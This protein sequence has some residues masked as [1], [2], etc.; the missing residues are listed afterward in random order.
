MGG[1]SSELEKSVN[2][3]QTEL[4][5][6][7]MV[8]DVTVPPAFVT[9]DHFIANWFLWKDKFLAYLKKIDKAEDKKQLW[10]IMLLNRMGPVGQEI[11]RTFPFYN[12]NAQE[13]INVLI[14]KFDIYCMYRNEK[15][16]CKDINRYTSDLIF[17]AVTWNHVDPTGIVKE[18]IIQDISTQRFTGNAALLIES[19]GENLIPYLQSLS[20]NEIILYWKLQVQEPVNSEQ[21]EF[22]NESTVTAVTVPPI[23]ATKDHLIANWFSWKNEFLAYLRRI[24][25]AGDNRHLWG[26]MLLNRMGPVGQK[27]HRTFTFYDKNEQ[28]DITALI[29]RFDIYCMYGD[30]KRGG[31]D[32]DRYINDLIFIAVTWNHDD[33][34]AIVKEKIIQDISAQRFTGKAALLIESKGENFIPYLQSL[35]LNEIILFW[36]QCEDLMAQKIEETPKRDSPYAEPTGVE[37]TRSSMEHKRNRCPAWRNCLHLLF[38]AQCN[39]LKIYITPDHQSAWTL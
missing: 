4:P 9:K 38:C 36:K 22:P 37:Y 28:E 7:S 34:A 2:S 19:K 5:N 17:I 18:K 3:E 29:K 35:G 20:L 16:G 15:R 23:F 25:K 31:E 32:I 14:K 27:I 6:G 1:S 10:G 26:I 30:A 33:P 12:K 39:K 13:D 21:A 24:D 11:H 8:T